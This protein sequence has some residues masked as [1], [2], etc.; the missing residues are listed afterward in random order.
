MANMKF[1][2][3]EERI[4]FDAALAL[5]VSPPPD[6][7]IIYVNGDLNQPGDGLTWETA[8]NSFDLALQK[9]KITIGADQIWLADGTYKPSIATA[10]NSPLAKPD[11][12]LCLWLVCWA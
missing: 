5:T 10:V 2:A 1:F 12:T 4:V 8:F 3:L 6:T 11:S 9:A 7:P